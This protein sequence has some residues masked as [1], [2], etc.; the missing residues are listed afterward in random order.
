MGLITEERQAE[1]AGGRMGLGRGSYAGS[2]EAEITLGMRSLLGIFF[3]LVLI[4]GIFFGFGYSVGRSGGSRAASQDE[5][6]ATN[7][8]VNAN[9]K[10]PSAQ[11]SLTP[12]PTLAPVAADDSQA[13]QNST[14]SAAASTP[15]PQTTAAPAPTPVAAAA[16]PVTRTVTVPTQ[17]AQTTPQHYTAPAPTQT[18]PQRFAAAAPATPAAPQHFTTSGPMP[19]ISSDTAPASAFM[20]QIAA[21][22]LQQDANVLVTAL[23]RRGYS[24]VVRNESQDTLLHV[25]IGPFPSRNAAF[26]MRSRL[27]ADGYN[28]VVK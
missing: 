5:A 22:R 19:V 14:A 6:A 2:E 23:Q 25:Q 10:K 17:T 20:V 27:L 16:P 18:E 1:M 15:V 28:A 12:A 21:V 7:A 26:A 13:A 3:G 24:V 4:C 9:L 8:A 11:Q